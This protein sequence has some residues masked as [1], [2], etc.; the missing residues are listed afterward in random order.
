MVSH[1]KKRNI[2]QVKLHTNDYEVN[3]GPCWKA[4]DDGRFIFYLF[5][6]FL[7]FFFL[8][9]GTFREKKSAQDL[10][11][12]QSRTPFSAK[13]KLMNLKK[14]DFKKQQLLSF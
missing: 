6:F 5:V 11:V 7:G 2:H 12:P 13:K 8:M 9:K 4:T 1:K 3:G 10:R 14:S